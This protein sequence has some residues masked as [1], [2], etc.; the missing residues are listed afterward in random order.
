MC[1]GYDEGFA[2]FEERFADE[3]GH[4][5]EWNAFVKNALHFRIAAGES[6]ADDDEV[7]CGIEV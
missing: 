6:I 2:A 4:R 7:G 1:A 3:G 5:G